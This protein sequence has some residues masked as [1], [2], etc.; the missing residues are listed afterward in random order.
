MLRM[1]LIGLMFADNVQPVETVDWPD[2]VAV[3]PGV[4]APAH[5]WGAGQQ[6]TPQPAHQH[7][8]PRHQP[9]VQLTLE[10]SNIQGVCKK[11]GISV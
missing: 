8:A 1:V 4:V 9:P 2:V 3:F 11:R 6:E 10:V 7:Q 5:Q